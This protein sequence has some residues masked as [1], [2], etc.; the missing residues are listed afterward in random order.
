MKPIP[1]AKLGWCLLAT[2]SGQVTS[3]KHHD[4]AALKA[5]PQLTQTVLFQSAVAP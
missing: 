2:L 5:L 1:V 3:I 4:L